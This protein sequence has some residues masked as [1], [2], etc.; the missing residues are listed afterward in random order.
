MKKVG[1]WIDKRNAKIVTIEAGVNKLDTVVSDIENFNIRGGSG[2]KIK[3]GPQ[4]VVQDS[5]YLQREKHQLSEFFKNIAKEIADADALVI[6]GPAQTGEKFYNE[7]SQKY[8]QLHWKIKSVQKADN[9]TDNQIIAW[10]RKYYSS[11]N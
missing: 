9:M 8:S 10:V 11:D 6:F 7:L 2:T 5:K 3:G 1:I 4:D